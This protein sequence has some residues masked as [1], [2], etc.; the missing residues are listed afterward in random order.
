METK[1]GTMTIE[2]ARIL[3]AEAVAINGHVPL[4]EYQIRALKGLDDQGRWITGCPTRS[5]AGYVRIKRGAGQATFLRA[6]RAILAHRDEILQRRAETLA[7]AD[8]S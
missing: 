3:L 7:A 4:D 5:L 8:Q 1:S 6:C 2:R